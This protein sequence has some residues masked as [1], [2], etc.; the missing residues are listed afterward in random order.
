MNLDVRESRVTCDCL[1]LETRK[2]LK[3]VQ[4]EAADGREGPKEQKFLRRLLED[5][6]CN[7]DSGKT[8]EARALASLEEAE[9]RCPLLDRCPTSCSCTHTPA[10][11]E[12]RLDCTLMPGSV[13]TALN[14]MRPGV[15]GNGGWSGAGANGF[16][17]VGSPTA[18]G[19]GGQ[20]NQQGLPPE[21]ALLNHRIVLNLTAAETLVP[22]GGSE[23]SGAV[24]AVLT[25]T[26]VFDARRARLTR[27]VES[28]SVVAAA[29]RAYGSRLTSV[30]LAGNPFRC[31]CSHSDLS[32]LR[33]LRISAGVDDFAA[34]DCVFPDR[35]DVRVHV[36]N[37]LPT[38]CATT[39]TS[40]TATMTT[41]TT[42]LPPP[43][44]PPTLPLATT[45]PTT[46]ATS[47]TT[48]ALERVDQ[49]I[50]RTEAPTETES[51]TVAPTGGGSGVMLVV[52]IACAL[53][54][55]LIFLSITL[56][57]L[58]YLYQRDK[59]RHRNC[60]EHSNRPQNMNRIYNPIGAGVPVNG[61]TVFALNPLTSN[62]ESNAFSSSLS[63]PDD[64][65]PASRRQSTGFR[66]RQ[67]RQQQRLPGT[68]LH[69]SRPGSDEDSP[70]SHSPDR[71]RLHRGLLDQQQNR[72]R[73]L[74]MNRDREPHYANEH[75]YANTV[76]LLSSPNAR[77]RPNFNN[78]NS[79]SSNNANNANNA[80]N[81]NG[82][83]N[84]VGVAAQYRPS[85]E[86]RENDENALLGGCMSNASTP[87][88]SF[89][90]SM[91]P[92]T[93]HDR[94]TA[95]VQRGSIFNLLQRG[96]THLEPRPHS[97]SHSHSAH[98]P[99]PASV[100]AND[101]F[102]FTLEP[103]RTS[104]TPP[105]TTTT[106]AT[107]TSC[108]AMNNGE[109]DSE[110][111]TILPS[112]SPTIQRAQPHHQQPQPTPTSTAS[113]SV[114]VPF[115]APTHR[116]S[117]AAAIQL[118][119]QLHS[120]SLESTRSQPLCR[121]SRPQQQHY[122]PNPN[123]RRNPNPQAQSQS[124]VQSP[125]RS[126]CA[127][128]NQSAS[129][130]LLRSAHTPQSVRSGVS[131]VERAGRTRSRG[132]LLLEHDRSSDSTHSCTRQQLQEEISFV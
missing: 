14:H 98:Q 9:L 80:N 7:A 27:L 64:S 119:T 97:H 106:T 44:L 72:D 86:T 126:L 31:T 125:N 60:R 2:Y 32:A 88:S 22:I 24:L 77:S 92:T 52:L 49:L 105:T 131:V 94:T 33:Q 108:S 71:L 123:P 42:T 45:A 76:E 114:S 84:C 57:I 107:T 104:G 48:T 55:V 11:L 89:A 53:L 1:L 3:S 34:L 28:L 12:V 43:P 83:G 103:S 95:P 68:F 91:S 81:V 96:L 51:D 63:L 40:T 128:D 132:D 54:L 59:L 115:A 100:N 30:Q 65:R 85:G 99:P 46:T 124:Q 29:R 10:I 50:V 38:I 73:G 121:E 16:A 20:P 69:H 130:Q 39:A 36:V 8:L 62:R 13:P 37:E 23:S 67:S 109:P 56:C 47:P 21:I 66:E 129:Q 61:S 101:E 111:E 120:P 78:S 122:H 112:Q 19:Q 6:R 113:A 25:Q 58:Y 127:R 102:G 74:Q 18:V 87:T 82:N 117:T 93:G 70:D 75:S 5:M 41:T 17:G 26:S 35:P 90:S 4:R 15:G 118:Q 79:S 110:L 116:S